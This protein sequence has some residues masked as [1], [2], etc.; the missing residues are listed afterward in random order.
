MTW[1][2][3]STAPASSDR[4]WIRF[5]IQ[6]NSSDDQLL[7]DEGLD[8]LL[9]DAGREKAAEQA[10]RT[11]A[12]KFARRADKEV[13]KL[14]IASAQLA[15]TYFDLADA[16]KQEFAGSI[17]GGASGMY[18]GGTSLS[19]MQTEIDDDDRPEPAFKRKQFDFPG[20]GDNDSDRRDLLR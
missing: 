8:L 7:Q 9:E 19:D 15:K 20:S 3:L 2:Y 18:A 4:S 5:R 13:G 12:A 16:L 17:T 14:R 10:A 1:S 6:D 11:V